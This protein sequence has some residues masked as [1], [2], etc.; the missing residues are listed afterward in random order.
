M[1]LRAVIFDF[2]GIIVESDAIKTEAFV[3]VAEAFFPGSREAMRAYHAI[4]RGVSRY[5]K[6]AWLCREFSNRE[7]TPEESRAMAEMYVGLTLDA[8]LACPAVPGFMETAGAWY[9]R[10]PLFVASGTPEEEL[11]AILHARDLT[12]FFKGISGTPPEKEF[13]LRDILRNADV[14]PSAA[15]MVGDSQTDMD[16]AIANGTKFFGR[17][18]Q[19]KNS[20][21]PWH[22]DLAPLNAYLETLASLP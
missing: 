10:V 3:S 12:P 11:A 6:F 15:V 8:V 9:G 22:T 13:L 7:I 1:A 2:D 4:H 17:G 20:G 5:G 21:F 18:E 16:A 14:P 19:F